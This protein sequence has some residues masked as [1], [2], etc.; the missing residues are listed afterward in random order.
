M[1][2]C[3]LES[4]NNF[5]LQV[6]K[7]NIRS[8][9]SFP[10]TEIGHLLNRNLM[11]LTKPSERLAGIVRTAGTIRTPSARHYDAPV[12]ISKHWRGEF[13]SFVA[14]FYGP[15][16]LLCLATFV[17]RRQE[18][19]DGEGDNVSCW[20]FHGD[21]RRCE[22]GWPFGHGGDGDQ[23]RVRRWFTVSRQ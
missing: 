23:R 14:S 17:S 22:S 9:Q 15:S 2:K 19:P 7:T 13:P 4:W 11:K 1:Q 3:I 8:W 5:Y 16:A 6:V 12:I 21:P 18:C 20:P 10:D